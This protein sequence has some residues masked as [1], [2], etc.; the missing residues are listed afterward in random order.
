M[1]ANRKRAGTN[2][3]LSDIDRIIHQ[4][5]RLSIMAHLA[6]VEGADFLFL[7]RQTELTRGNLS[8]HLSK[9]ERAGYLAVEKKFVGKMPKTL[10]SLTEE[11]R[12]AFREY[13]RR[14]KRM[15]EELPG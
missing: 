7:L 15:L 1:A 14:M 8:A 5:A 4:P 6:V 11:G 13:R 9:L 10:L 2:R 3:P 12:R